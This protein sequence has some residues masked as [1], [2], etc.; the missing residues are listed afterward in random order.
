MSFAPSVETTTL[1]CIN[2]VLSELKAGQIEARMLVDLAVAH[3]RQSGRRSHTNANPARST[4]CLNDRTR[5]LITIDPGV[6]LYMMQ[7]HGMEAATIEDLISSDPAC[8]ACHIFP[9]TCAHCEPRRSGGE[10]SERALRLRIV[11]ELGSLVAALGGVD[12]LVFS[13]RISERDALTSAEVVRSLR[14]T[15]AILD[16]TRNGHNHEGLISATIHLSPSGSSTTDEERLVARRTAAM[17]GRQD[18]RP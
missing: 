18:A 5:G 17:L 1:E 11:R 12:G 9:L 13:A 10:G 4:G 3:N 8:S 6:I 2:T 15:G 7:R 16:P 14:W